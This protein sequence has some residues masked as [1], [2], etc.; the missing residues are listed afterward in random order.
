[1]LSINHIGFTT[2][3]RASICQ[4]FDTVGVAFSRVAYVRSSLCQVQLVS[5]VLLSGGLGLA[6]HWGKES[7][8]AGAFS[9]GKLIL[10]LLA[11]SC[12]SEA[13]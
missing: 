4:C 3:A 8:S 11:D 13:L 6:A 9:L 12:G 7:Y 1:M 5:G 2:A 10:G